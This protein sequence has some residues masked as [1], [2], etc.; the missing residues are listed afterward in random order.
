MRFCSR[1]ILGI[2][3]GPQVG[4]RTWGTATRFLTVG[5]TFTASAL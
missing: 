4:H 1:A 5:D 2:H 3:L